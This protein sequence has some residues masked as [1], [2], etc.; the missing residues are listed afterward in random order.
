MPS[1]RPP[2]R[3]SI[4]SRQFV[5]DAVRIQASKTSWGAFTYKWVEAYC[6]FI[7]AYDPSTPFITVSEAQHTSLLQLV[8]AEKLSGLWTT[9]ELLTLSRK[10]YYLD[11]RLYGPR[12]LAAPK[13]KFLICTL[14]NGDSELLTDMAAYAKLPW[15]AAA[16]ALGLVIDECAL[17]AAHLWDLQA[18]SKY[19]Y[20][21][22][23]A[24]RAYQEEWS[25]VE[26]KRARKE[27]WVDK[28]LT[29][30]EGNFFGGGET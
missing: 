20:Q 26:V 19:G 1:Q 12:G 30:D 27:G 7:E 29:V 25:R 28:W 11:P 8:E 9:E 2:S 14:S 22:I 18:A 21:T 17:V 3:N 13:Q 6:N 24:E 5:P 4:R 10:W 15:N 23:Y 16:K